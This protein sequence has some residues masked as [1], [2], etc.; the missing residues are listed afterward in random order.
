MPAVPTISNEERLEALKK[1]SAL[2]S[3]RAELRAALKAGEIT[4]KDVVEN[5]DAAAQGMKVATLIATL[6]GYGTVK[7]QKVMD[8]LGIAENRRIRGLGAKQ[9]EA[10]LAYFA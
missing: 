5:P 2:R 8:E 1:A 3:A 4:I 6:P 7:T 10:L 9:K